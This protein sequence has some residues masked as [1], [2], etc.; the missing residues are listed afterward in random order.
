MIREKMRAIETKLM[1]PFTKRIKKRGI[2]TFTIIKLLYITALV[3]I[4]SGIVSVLDN[5]VNQTYLIYP[6]SGGQ[7]VIE[8][9]LYGFV[10]AM[11]VAGVYLAIESGKT[12]VKHKDHYLAISLILLM[13]S[14]AL[15]I[16][17]VSAK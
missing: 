9:F 1:G 3:V 12:M 11:G 10:V 8:T 5:P 4:F 14:V 13:V 6:S 16:F 17:I 7:S 2:Q 15:G